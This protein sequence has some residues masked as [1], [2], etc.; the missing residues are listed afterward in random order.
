MSMQLDIFSDR[1][2]GSIAEWQAAIDAQG[3]PLR[4]MPDAKI[5]RLAGLLP[6]HLGEALTGFECFHENA[7]EVMQANADIDFGHSWKHCFQFVWLG[8]RWYELVAAWMAAVAFVKAT[9]GVIFDCEGGK[10]LTPDEACHLVYELEKPPP[11]QE[12]AMQEIRRE[13]GSDP[14]PKIPKGG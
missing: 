13:T 12:A 9:G 2:L 5:D 1:Q 6:C 7:A 4:L 11:A 14:W 10:L 3:Y 8:S